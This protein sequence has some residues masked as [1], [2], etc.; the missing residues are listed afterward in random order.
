MARKPVE[1]EE[2]PATKMHQKDLLEVEELRKT[3]YLL[4][5]LLLKEE[6]EYEEAEHKA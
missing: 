1:E 3:G 4:L 5:L 2:E 6:S